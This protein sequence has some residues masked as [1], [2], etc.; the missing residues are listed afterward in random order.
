MK[1]NHLKTLAATA[2]TP[3]IIKRQSVMHFFIAF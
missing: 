2:T 1:T 3:Q